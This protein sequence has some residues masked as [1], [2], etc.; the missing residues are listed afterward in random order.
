MK[1][2]AKGDSHLCDM[3]IYSFWFV[4]VNVGFVSIWDVKE[5]RTTNTTLSASTERS[6]WR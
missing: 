1:H 4:H 2:R 6:T 5:L 3:M